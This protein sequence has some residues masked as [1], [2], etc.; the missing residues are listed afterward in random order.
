MGCNK[1]GMNDAK[2]GCILSTR[3]NP[4]ALS[5]A[6]QGI[7]SWDWRQSVSLSPAVVP[8]S[9]ARMSEAAGFTVE[10]LTYVRNLVRERSGIVLEEDKEYLIFSRLDSLARELKFDSL[11]E[12][13]RTLRSTANDRLHRRVVEAMITNETSFFRDLSPFLVLKEYLLPNLI[14]R[15]ASVKCLSI[16][17]GASSSG[18]EPYSILLTI[19][20]HFP[21]LQDWQIWMLATDISA[22]MLNRCREG[23]YSQLEVNRGLPAHILNKYFTKKGTHWQISAHLR[24]KIEFREMNLAGPWP[25][26]PSLD[27]V[28]LRNVLIYFDEETKKRILKKIRHVL[29]P[30]GYLLLGGTETTIHLDDHYERMAVNGTAYYRIRTA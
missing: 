7:S 30:D 3:K 6:P 27:L 29:N 28:V 13:G 10:D 5:P 21:E 14:A 20:E 19:L 25:P 15:R 23:L 22:A 4:G 2:L 18:Q 11:R 17:C 16:W 9:G 12:L 24:N 1:G 8:E 26:F